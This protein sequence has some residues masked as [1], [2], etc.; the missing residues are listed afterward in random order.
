MTNRT[1]MSESE[2]YYEFKARLN[3]L[4]KDIE[5]INEKKAP[6]KWVCQQLGITEEQA[7]SEIDGRLE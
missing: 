5:E 7:R 2:L 1:E 3:K 4:Q 6:L